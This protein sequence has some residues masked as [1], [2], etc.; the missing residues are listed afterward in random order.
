MGCGTG[1]DQGGD[2]VNAPYRT[3][4]FG[5]SPET[6]DRLAYD[7]HELVAGVERRRN[8]RRDAR[9]HVRRLLD[10]AKNFRRMLLVAHRVGAVHIREYEDVARASAHDCCE[11]FRRELYPNLK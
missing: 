9:A 1:C 3:D 5:R 4:A 7:I 11:A 6:L 8:A 2:A 10:E